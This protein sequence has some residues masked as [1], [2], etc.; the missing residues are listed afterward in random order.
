MV[1]FYLQSTGLYEDEKFHDRIFGRSFFLFDSVVPER[2]GFAAFVVG[3]YA[4]ASR[5]VDKFRCRT[6]D[7]YPEI[8]SI[9]RCNRQRMTS[10]YLENHRIIALFVSLKSVA[11]VE[12][13]R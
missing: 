2:G 9:V 3:I 5:N 12:H 11:F 4:L 8:L 10:S 6:I 7:E 13:E 1:L